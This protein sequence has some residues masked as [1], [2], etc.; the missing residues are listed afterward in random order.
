M[1]LLLTHGY[2]LPEDPAEKLVMKPYPPLGLLYISAY[3][4]AKGFD[5]GVLD[6]TFQTFDEAKRALETA[7]PSIVGIYC[8]LMTRPNVLKLI[9]VCEALGATVILGGPEP[10]NYAEQYLRFGADLIVIGEAELT[11]EELVPLLKEDGLQDLNRVPGI[12]FQNEDSEIIRTEARPLHPNLDDFPYPDRGAIELRR[13]LDTWR[14]HHGAGSV[15]LICARGCPYTCTWCSHSVYGFTHRRRSPRN[16]ADEVQRIR[17]EYDPEM[18]WYADD[19]FTIHHRWLA[20]YSGELAKRNIR[21]PFECISREDRLNETVIGQLAKMGCYRLWIGSESGSQS[22]LDAMQRRTNVERVQEVTKLL[23]KHGIEAGMFIMLGYEGETQDDLEAT[24]A[25]LKKSN[26]DV[27][28]T[29]VAYPIK[30]TEYYDQLDGRVVSHGSWQEQTDR[31]LLVAGRRSRRYYGFVN[32]WLVHDVALHR[33]LSNGRPKSTKVVGHFL[34]AKLGRLG[35][36][37]TKHKK[38]KA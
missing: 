24:A 19:V 8:N 25:H 37:L 12:I 34:N 35:M 14:E 17:E 10:S 22:I 5:I 27:F 31:D 6:T 13:Y 11:L 30:G 9:R 38:V 26:P 1:D 2:F 16:V 23:Q 15:S 28:L 36:A 18:L 33:Q 20:D 7:K 3:L 32:R 21:L 29:T 4:K